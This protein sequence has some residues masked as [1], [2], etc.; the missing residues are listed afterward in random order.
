MAIELE[1]ALETPPGEALRVG[2]VA[3]KDDAAEINGLEEERKE[4]DK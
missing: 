2:A 3:E 1:T 4:D